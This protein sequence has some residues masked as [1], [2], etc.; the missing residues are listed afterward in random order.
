VQFEDTVAPTIAR[1]GVRVYDEHGGPLTARAGARVV[2]SGRVQVVIDAW[3]QADG[4]RP[5]RRL[6]LYDVGY[7]VLKPDGTPAPGSGMVRHRLRFDRL[8]EQPGAAALVYA[9]GSGIPFYG[10]RRTQFLYRATSSLRDGVAAEGFWDTTQLP[11]GDYILRAW[12]ADI[13]G[14][15]ATE[16]RDLPITIVSTAEARPAG[17]GGRAGAERAPR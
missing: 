13:R 15:V 8:T 4:N 14:N 6:G 16:H 2:V 10:Q 5:E 1:G 9:P 17:P 11:P 7:Q 3:D 12:V